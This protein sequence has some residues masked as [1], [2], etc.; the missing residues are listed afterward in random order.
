M[1]ALEKA[2]WIATILDEKKGQD[3]HILHVTDKTIITDYFVIAGGTTHT[4]L[5]ALADEV[6]FRL[7]EKSMEP[8]STEGYSTGG[9]ILQDFGDV[10]V[11]LFD[12]S[13]REFYKLEKLWSEA[14]EIAF[15]KKED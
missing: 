8:L 3:V 12:P 9:W 11:H 15:E 6:E 10:L 14:E 2:R 7:K 13:S 5:K 1:T 4:H